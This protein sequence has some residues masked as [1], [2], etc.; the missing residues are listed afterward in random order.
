MTRDSGFPSIRRRSVRTRER[1][2]GAL[3]E[4]QTV[5]KRRGVIRSRGAPFS[6]ATSR[7]SSSR[8]TAILTGASI[9]SFTRLWSID[10]TLT[11]MPPSMTIPG[12][13]NGNPTAVSSS[14][15]SH[16]TGMSG[17]TIKA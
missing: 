6:P 10:S 9:P 14:D 4:T 15:C 11:V 1:R 16:S 2:G 8:S 13:R 7:S 3:Q 12:S 5:A 17:S